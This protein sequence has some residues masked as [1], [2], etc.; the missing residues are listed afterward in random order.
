MVD[1]NCKLESPRTFQA[2]QTYTNQPSLRKRGNSGGSGGV[3]GNGGN[4]S[5]GGG[6]LIGRSGGSGGNGGSGGQ[7]F[8]SKPAVKTAAPWRFS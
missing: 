1:S 4:A 5:N 8:T 3:G 6:G 7:I 2:H